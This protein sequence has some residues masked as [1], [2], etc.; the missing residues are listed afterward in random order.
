MSLEST[1]FNYITTYLQSHSNTHIIIAYSGGVDSQ[2]LLHA[3]S[4]F[5][6]NILNNPQNI[7]QALSCSISV[8]HVN[9]G[10]SS[11][12]LKWENFA[13]QQCN[14]HQL[15][16]DICRVNVKAKAQHSLEELARDARYDALKSLIKN[17]EFKHVLVLTGHHNDDQAETFLLALKRGSGLKGLSAMKQEIKLGNALLVRPLL[18]VSR[19]QIEAYA[20][21]NN[22][23][24]IEDESNEDISFDRNFL[25]HKVMPV[26]TERWPSFLTTIN[27]STAHCQEAE[28]LLTEFAQQDLKRIQ[29]SK[30]A[31]CLAQIAAL[32]TPRFNNLIRYFLSENNC[33]MPSAAQLKQLQKQLL[34]ANDKVPAVKVGEHWLRRYK[35]A[36]YLTP[37]FN[38]VSN[39]HALVDYR[40]KETLNLP[41]DLGDLIFEQ[42]ETFDVENYMNNNG[43]LES[44]CF[45][46]APTVKQ[47]LSVRFKHANPTCIPDYRNHSRSL[48]KVLQE[49]DIPTWQRMRLPFIYYNEELVAVLGYF[50]CK[51]FLAS[52]KD[53]VLKVI[54][55]K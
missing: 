14:L 45:I 11:N 20:T 26:I 39:F 1:L 46:K 37:E 24:W 44:I 28:L 15:P 53:S 30:T 8:C 33:L 43:A 12:A 25:R 35:Q 3:L 31:L 23:A 9:H 6:N 50:V 7:N 54:W 27:R 41:D 4:N 32:S 18:N 13:Q 2:V 21:Q 10:L 17:K 48:K 29:V 55:N 38:D 36:V 51:E 47:Q 42:L 5:K 19:K 34:S 22:L 52:N 40:Q 16:L 49:L